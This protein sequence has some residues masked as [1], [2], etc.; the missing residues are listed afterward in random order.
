M[1]ATYEHFSANDLS[2]CYVDLDLD[3]DDVMGA[4]TE[5]SREFN[6]TNATEYSSFAAHGEFDGGMGRYG[7]YQSAPLF[8]GAWNEHNANF[9]TIYSI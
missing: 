1:N 8:S 9:S 7:S 6:I 2:S 5:V 4:Y 3:K